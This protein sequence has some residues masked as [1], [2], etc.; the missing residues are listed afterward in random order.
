MYYLMIIVSMH[1][2][3]DQNESKRGLRSYQLPW[4][5]WQEDKRLTQHWLNT[6]KSY[7][8]KKVTFKS[9]DALI[10]I[11]FPSISLD[12]ELK[13]VTQEVDWKRGDITLR[14]S[15]ARAVSILPQ[16][17]NKQ[18]LFQAHTC[19]PSHHIRQDFSCSK[20]MHIQITSRSTVIT[21]FVVAIV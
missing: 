11:A 4:T 8:L 20:H 21:K 18:H 2:Y 9:I 10:T 16:S 1:K 6:T 17:S 15:S 13:A 12:I 7:F 14:S 3:Y 5:L 19:L